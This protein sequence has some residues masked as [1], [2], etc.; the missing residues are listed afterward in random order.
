MHQHNGTINKQNDANN[1]PTQ[2]N[3]INVPAG[4]MVDMPLPLPITLHDL[5]VLNHSNYDPYLTREREKEW[6]GSN[7]CMPARKRSFRAPLVIAPCYLCHK[8]CAFF[9]VDDKKMA[10]TIDGFN[11]GHHSVIEMFTRYKQTRD[12]NW[13]IDTDNSPFRIRWPLFMTI[14]HANTTCIFHQCTTW[15]NPTNRQL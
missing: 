8:H 13:S 3:A 7:R 11:Y 15:K 6:I 5:I 10:K 2:I 4:F 14:D 1:R 12:A 9:Y